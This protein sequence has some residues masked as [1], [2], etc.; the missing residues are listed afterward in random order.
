MPDNLDS[1]EWNFIIAITVLKPIKDVTEK[2]SG[3]T[4][5]TPYLPILPNVFRIN[6]YTSATANSNYTDKRY[7]Q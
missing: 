2:M 4:Y 1:V 3:E 7:E 6:K 5:P